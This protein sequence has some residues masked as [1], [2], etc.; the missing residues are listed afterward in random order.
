MVSLE[1]YDFFDPNLFAS[2][3]LSDDF[4]QVAHAVDIQSS[5]FDWIYIQ[6]RHCSTHLWLFAHTTQCPATLRENLFAIRSRHLGLERILYGFNWH[7][8]RPERGPKGAAMTHKV[9]YQWLVIWTLSFG[10]CT[11]CSE[12]RS[13]ELDDMVG[14]GDCE[15][16]AQSVAAG[17]DSETKVVDR[18]QTIS[19][20][21]ASYG[22]ATAG[23]TA[24]VM[25]VAS[26]GVI[27]VVVLC[28]VTLLG[29]AA[30][31][32][33]RSGCG[34]I[35]HMV[36]FDNPGRFVP[37]VQDSNARTDTTH[38]NDAPTFGLGLG[39]GAYWQTEGWREEP[40]MLSLSRK[41]RKVAT[42]YE[43]QDTRESLVKASVQL[44]QIHESHLYDHIGST[45]RGQVDRDI[46]RVYARLRLIDPGYQAQVNRTQHELAVKVLSQQTPALWRDLETGSTWRFQLA[47]LKDGKQAK[48]VC[49][50]AATATGQV[51]Q[52][53]TRGDT[54]RAIKHGL[55]D[56]NKN[57]GFAVA[58]AAKASVYVRD[59]NDRGETEFPL[60]NLATGE[61]V[62]PGDR[63]DHLAVSLLCVE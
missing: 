28:P 41:L 21:A 40:G 52:L 53:P 62:N 30:C 36:C 19:G 57:Q 17:A 45:E 42:C 10:L 5:S 1:L 23:Y 34:A 26:A 16:A 61:M 24:D 6:H 35:G 12:H 31:T 47:S 9:T 39:S 32:S 48:M 60:F 37:G 18:V 56:A 46:G 7:H 44:Q 15:R 2:L 59:G 20:T 55:L 49:D 43:A 8:L 13:T 3:V 27:A 4:D 54:L 58:Q 14:S 25:V 50:H 22:L 33:A 63:A 38:P 51:W 11:G 29:I